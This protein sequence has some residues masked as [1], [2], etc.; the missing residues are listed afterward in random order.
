[1]RIILFSLISVIFT[2]FI[3]CNSAKDT[4]DTTTQVMMASFSTEEELDIASNSNN[5]FTFDAYHH[6]NLND[7]NTFLSGYS[8][9]SMLNILSSAASGETKTE[10]LKAANINTP[11]DSWEKY[12]A[13]LAKETIQ[14]VDKNNSGY[15]FL[16][17]NSFWVQEGHD[18]SADYKDALKKIYG[19]DVRVVDFESNSTAARNKINYWAS[20]M[21]VRID[22]RNF[23]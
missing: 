20:R 6:M 15:R 14:F 23:G 11:L 13:A 2:L 18:I 5:D 7:K 16:F 8:L 22:S 17:E 12:Y 1:M 19:V 4:T 21:T 9:F 3:G 10:I